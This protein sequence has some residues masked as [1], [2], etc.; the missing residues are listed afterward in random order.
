ML[1][2]AVTD[3]KTGQTHAI[4]L[5]RV[6]L[7]KRH[8]KAGTEVLFVDPEG[9]YTAGWLAKETPEEILARARVSLCGSPPEVRP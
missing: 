5:T 2:V 9:Q 3:R 7:L 8:P 6:C 4:D 1:W